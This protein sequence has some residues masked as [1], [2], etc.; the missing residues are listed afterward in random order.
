MV[1]WL[2]NVEVGKKMWEDVVACFKVLSQN[3]PGGTEENQEQSRVCV[4]LHPFIALQFDQ[5]FVRFP[6]SETFS[7][8]G[9]FPFNIVSFLLGQ[10]LLCFQVLEE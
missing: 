2:M 1:G 6:E 5:I 9:V 10:I 7:N 8:K 4:I 3:S